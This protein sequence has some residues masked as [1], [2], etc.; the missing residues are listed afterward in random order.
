[1]RSPIPLNGQTKSSKGL[2][3]VEATRTLGDCPMGWRLRPCGRLLFSCVNTRIATASPSPLIASPCTSTEEGLDK[4]F[5]VAERGGRLGG[6]CFGGLGPLPVPL[7]FAA[8]L[9]PLPLTGTAGFGSNDR[10]QAIHLLAASATK[11]L[12]GVFSGLKG[13]LVMVLLSTRVCC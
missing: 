9:F 4:D 12:D 6:P 5:E 1:M 7:L 13:G 8:T 11:D 3:G 10:N 2:E